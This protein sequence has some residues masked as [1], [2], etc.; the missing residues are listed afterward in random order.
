MSATKQTSCP[1]GVSRRSVIQ[2]RSK[3]NIGVKKSPT[4]NIRALPPVTRKPAEEKRKP[5]ITKSTVCLQ[6]TPVKSTWIETQTSP[7]EIKNSFIQTTPRKLLDQDVQTS[8]SHP[9][10]IL[11]IA[12]NPRTT[13]QTSPLRLHWLN[14][15]VKSVQT[16]V[17]K[18]LFSSS[19]INNFEN[20]TLDKLLENT[21]SSSIK[22]FRNRSSVATIYS[23]LENVDVALAFVYKIKDKLYISEGLSKILP[24]KP[25]SISLSNW[26]GLPQL[27]FPTN[28]S[29]VRVISGEKGRKILILYINNNNLEQD[30]E[31][32]FK[33]FDSHA[34]RENNLTLGVDT[35]SRPDVFNINILNL[36]SLI[37]KYNTLRYCFYYSRTSMSHCVIDYDDEEDDDDE[38]IS[39]IS[40]HPVGTFENFNSEETTIK[41]N[42][43]NVPSKSFLERR[44]S[45]SSCDLK[46]YFDLLAENEKLRQENEELTQSHIEMSH[47]LIKREEEIARLQYMQSQGPTTDIASILS[48]VTNLEHL[49]TNCNKSDRFK[50]Q[51]P[52]RIR[53][54][55]LSFSNVNITEIMPESV[56]IKNADTTCRKQINI[57]N[58]PI[59]A[60]RSIFSCEISDKPQSKI[61]DASNKNWLNDEDINNY[62]SYLSKKY[63]RED[64][65]MI[66]PIISALLLH[67]PKEAG[68]HLNC[69]KVKKKKFIILPVNDA[70]E[71]GGGSHWSLLFFDGQN[72]LY[73]YFDSLNFFN[74]NKAE[75]LA[76]NLCT[77][78][79]KKEIHFGSVQCPQ[80][81]NSY[82]CG[83]FLLYFAHNICNKIKRSSSITEN[84]YFYRSEFFI[85]NIREKLE[86]RE[87]VVYQ[88]KEQA[89]IHRASRPLSNSHFLDQGKTRKA[90]FKTITP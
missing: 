67:N 37:I 66:D 85:R 74:Q 24:G 27:M 64:T 55:N 39:V 70:D 68:K 11:Y 30:V 81:N 36:R 47:V 31:N 49:L 72:N 50:N 35:V 10:D 9:S 53:Q 13:T 34:T 8:P 43:P 48:K 54:P 59:P 19:A 87:S 51:C 52:V 61:N 46:G 90:R 56:T 44:K 28:N 84:W 82:D 78:L 89:S 17:K 83:V 18:S 1:A 40:D 25:K 62:L 76:R 2:T 75:K 21:R 22:H 63:A 60:K 14:A 65:I 6:T 32:I 41:T 80:Q 26:E 57:P 16:K 86:N 38:K 58:P 45:L 3:M 5:N 71:H 69:L 20:L 88:M 73:W 33:I 7:I 77:Y 23:F 42:E 4:T 15:S 29:E 79:D 12:L